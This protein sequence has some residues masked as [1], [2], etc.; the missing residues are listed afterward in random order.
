MYSMFS[1]TDEEEEDNSE[2]E[3]SATTDIEANPPL[4]K[5][6]NTT[7]QSKENLRQEDSTPRQRSLV[8]Q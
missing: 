5:T 6:E 4:F 3:K 2:Q 1:I 7:P 8:E